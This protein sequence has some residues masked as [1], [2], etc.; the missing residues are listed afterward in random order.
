L[1]KTLAISKSGAYK[2]RDRRLSALSPGPGAQL[3]RVRNDGRLL[4][5]RIPLRLTRIRVL[6]IAVIAACLAGFSVDGAI[7]QTATSSS[8][9]PGALFQQG[10]E[11]LQAGQ[12]HLAEKDFRGVIALDPKSAAP[13]INLGVTYMREKRWD[14]ALVELRKAESLAPNQSGVQLNI[15]LA[16]YRKNDF[17]SA[18][19]P[20]AAT[21]RLEPAS[22]QARYLLGLCYFFTN[23]YKEAAD[24][25]APLWEQESTK[26]N[27][28]YVLSIAASK[29]S[30]PALQKRAFDRMLAI[31]QDKP[32]FHL[33]VGKAWLAEHAT[34]KALDEFHSAA[35]ARPDLPLV[36]FF[37]GRTYLEQRDYPQAEAELEKDI[38]VEPNFAYSYEDLG[39]LYAQL[40]QPEKA[41][42]YYREAVG[43]NDQLVNSWFGL[44]KLDRDSGRYLEAL[45]MLDHAEALAPQSGS[46]HYTRGQVLVHLGQSAKARQEFET[47]ARLLRS[48]NDRLQADPS[49]DQAADAQ[50]A[51]EQ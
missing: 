28:L 8:S 37:L 10:K 16:Y 35:G 11:A 39:I 22:A 47:S 25:L 50:D 2:T 18:I 14:D 6:S 30:N 17:A 27:Y 38:A 45:Q 21:L 24:S 9:D 15:G 51:A 31:G 32:E 19:E 13:H 42:R 41:E 40:N 23:K 26:L 49:G 4:N 33:Y 48:F 5:D 3:H 12:L 20:F 46:V 1:L 36:H 29:S 7:G 34:D 43:R 44:A